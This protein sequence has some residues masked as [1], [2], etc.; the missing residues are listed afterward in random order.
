MPLPEPLR[1]RASDAIP[2]GVVTF[3]FTDIEGS[4]AR[5]DRD[6]NA[7]ADAVRRHDA[8]VRAAIVAK[9]GYVFKTLGDAFCAAFQRP[10]DAIVAMLE[11]RD[12][13]ASE[14][15]SAVGDIRIRAAIHTGTADERDGDYF[16]P[17]VNRVAR[18]VAIAHGGQLLVSGT[19]SALVGAGLPPRATLRD[20]GEH[21]LKDLTQSE[22]VYQLDARDDAREFPP[23]R[24]LD[25]SFNNLPLQ[26][27]S[28]V[29]REAEVAD[30]TALLAEHRLV[31][32]VGSGGVGKTRTSLQVAAEM[33][34]VPGYGVWFVEL[35][36]ISNGDYVP[37]TVAQ[38]M[39][40]SLPPAGESLANLVRAL[41]KTKA[42]LVFDNCE[43]LI[44]AASYVIDEI[45]RRCP[46]IRVLAS[47]RQALGIA[48][49]ASFRM[50]SLG[51]PADAET[52]TMTAAAALAFP[53]VAL[54]VARAIAAD[55]RFTLDD[56][57]APAVAEIARRLDGIPLAL[58][59]AAARVK[60]LRP[61]QIRDRL[62]ER[63]R[64]LTGG[65][66]AALPRQQT[67]RALIDWS[68]DLLDVRE[69]TLFRRLG[70]FAGDFIL[71]AA[72]A[73]GSG[74][75]LDDVACFDAL[76]SLVDKS[77]VLA[78]PDGDLFRYRL[79]ESTREYAR[80]KLEA[81]GEREATA[82]RHLHSLRDRFVAASERYH[83]TAR[84][85]EIVSIFGPELE[86][87]RAALEVALQFEGEVTS[88]AELLAAIGTSWNAF[89]S[90]ADGISRLEAFAGALD[91]QQ[92]SALRA[93]LL[94]ALSRLLSDAGQRAK[95]MDL[96][97]EAV[98]LARAG[99]KTNVLVRA[100]ES[101]AISLGRARRFD[102][103]DRALAEAEAI[104]NPPALL[105]L[106]L[107]STRSFLNLF[108][109]DLDGAASAYEQLLREHRQIGNAR[110]VRTITL[111]LAEVE[112]ARGFTERS[113]ALLRD[114]VPEARAG[115]DRGMFATMLANFAGYLVAV[116]ETAAAI[117]VAREAI[118]ELAARDPE[119]YN[120]AVS[121]EH[122]ALALALEGDCERA[123]RLSGYADA[124]FARA[125]FEREFTETTTYDRLRG[126]LRE[127]FREEQLATLLASGATLT[128]E[129]AVALALRDA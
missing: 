84:S 96:A 32:L 42:L 80:E 60:I 27:T 67:L 75:G 61:R 11:A 81:A 66:R 3:V 87:V 20:L 15:F 102:E 9:G 85:D 59:L 29:G 77:L 17:V 110:F 82:I 89:G 1:D 124:T 45:L 128:P 52:A 48:G 46:E 93:E 26:V 55:R 36:P 129:D 24:S 13:L 54:F 95:A 76:A 127:A 14:D 35:A 114:V 92:S 53:A 19:T 113:V 104:P 72:I 69:Q 103:A 94:D 105:R 121:A 120:L 2:S 63:F 126:M 43:H 74:D 83:R 18:L 10:E 86:D 111:S 112:H 49:E 4:T 101:H 40:I 109:G 106:R 119:S 8:L 88:G 12:A 125:Q 22:N 62:G 30:V 33:A 115:G 70:I 23:L 123:A 21:R 25:V 100:I 79:L 7:M 31:T 107:L 38:A 41:L 56:D 108:L 117:D 58:E 91:G 122:L 39:G 64:V 51:F 90:D 37:A 118:R 6:P 57:N 73:V 116:N 97:V 65:S 99:A 34:S 44:D 5:W 98:A 47:S 78:E 68:H 71:D 16:G 50:P 28:F